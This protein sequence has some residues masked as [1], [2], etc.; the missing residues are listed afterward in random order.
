MKR[1]HEQENPLEPP[2][3]KIKTE[4]L[5]KDTDVAVLTQVKEKLTNESNYINEQMNKIREQYYMSYMEKVMESLP[6]SKNIIESI[7]DVPIGTE[8]FLK[9]FSVA[10]MVVSS[11]IQLKKLKAFNSI[12]DMANK[13]IGRVIHDRYIIPL[14][15]DYV[16]PRQ[17]QNAFRAYDESLTSDDENQS[18]ELQCIAYLIQTELEKQEPLKVPNPL[19]NRFTQQ[20]KAISEYVTVLL[21][22][23]AISNVTGNKDLEREI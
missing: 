15:K 2:N 12:Y 19:F 14:M 4:H 9:M 18:L 22:S 3:S 6:I 11:E 13:L 8:G 21:S 16:S 10:K 17:L 23:V 5:V 7:N 20:M 1:P